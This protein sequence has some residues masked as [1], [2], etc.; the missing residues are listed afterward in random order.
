MQR[1][2]EETCVARGH[3]AQSWQEGDV[4]VGSLESLGVHFCWF[5]SG[6]MSSSESTDKVSGKPVPNRSQEGHVGS[7]NFHHSLTRQPSLPAH[8]GS[9]PSVVTVFWWPPVCFTP[10]GNQAPEV[11]SVL[12]SQ[13]QAGLL[14][15]FLQP[16]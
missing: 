13:S 4:T 11:P 10:S 1:R 2:R 9:C 12:K 16:P 5:S 6:E 8:G 7:R 14:S 15:G 3:T